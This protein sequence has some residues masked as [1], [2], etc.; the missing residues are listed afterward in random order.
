[1]KARRNRISGNCQES[2]PQKGQYYAY[3]CLRD[4]SLGKYTAARTKESL[5]Y[6][7]NSIPCAASTRVLLVLSPSKQRT[8]WIWAPCPY[9]SHRVLSYRHNPGI[10]LALFTRP[11]I[12]F[13]IAPCPSLRKEFEHIRNFSDLSF[14]L[15]S[16]VCTAGCRITCTW[17]LSSQ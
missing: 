15:N 1:M 17:K 14:R 9:A 3:P 4:S 11:L 16:S 6:S 13:D 7:S 5:K 10:K 8:G 2:K 12:T